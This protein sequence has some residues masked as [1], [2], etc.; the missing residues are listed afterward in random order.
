MT[1]PICFSTNTRHFA[2]KDIYVFYRCELCK[3]L[4]LKN[5]PPQTILNS[6]YKNTFSYKDGLNNEVVIRK[7]SVEILK[8]IIRFASNARSVCDIGSG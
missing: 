1:C 5:I 4:F 6:Y 2:N 7:R 3:T 8:N